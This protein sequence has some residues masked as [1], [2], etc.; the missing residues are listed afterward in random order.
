MKTGGF[1]PLVAEPGLLK[2]LVIK[3]WSPWAF[4]IPEDPE[5]LG[6]PSDDGICWEHPTV[7][8]PT[9]PAGAIVGF[10][11]LKREKIC[12]MRSLRAEVAQ[13]EGRTYMVPVLLGVHYLVSEVARWTGSKHEL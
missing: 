8:P 11:S 2:Q 1:S 9:D 4:A 13:A 12:T 5:K 7:C 10:A 6:V 3:M